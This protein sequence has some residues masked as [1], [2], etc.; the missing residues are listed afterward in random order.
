MG[1]VALVRVTATRWLTCQVFDRLNFGILPDNR[2]RFSLPSAT[3]YASTVIPWIDDVAGNPKLPS[4]PAPSLYRF[5]SYVSLPIASRTGHSMTP[6]KGGITAS[7]RLRPSI[8]F[9]VKQLICAGTLRP[10]RRKKFDWRL[11]KL[12]AVSGGSSAKQ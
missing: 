3:A 1:F 2:L 5:N 8:S 11:L 9:V 7:R 6:T 10:V 4:H 12:P